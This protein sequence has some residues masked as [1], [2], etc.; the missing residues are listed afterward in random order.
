MTDSGIS[1]TDTNA[2]GWLP[3]FPLITKSVELN[4]GA[5]LG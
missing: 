3:L 5:P 2:A 4:D 1:S